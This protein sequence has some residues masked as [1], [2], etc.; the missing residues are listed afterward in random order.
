VILAIGETASWLRRRVFEREKRMP[1]H[2]WT[3][4]KFHVEKQRSSTWKM[5]QSNR[6]QNHSKPLRLKNSGWKSPKAQAKHLT[7][8][9][10]SSIVDF[11]LPRSSKHNRKLFISYRRFFRKR[12]ASGR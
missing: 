6:N 3:K 11:W 9:R 5:P 12:N 7:N 1:S 10:T 8:H 2:E 4:R